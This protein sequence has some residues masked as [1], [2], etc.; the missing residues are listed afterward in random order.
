MN[1]H[2]SRS[3]SGQPTLSIDN[4]FIHSRYRPV[5]EARQFAQRL[6]VGSDVRLVIVL[7]DGL[8]YVSEAIAR[9]NRHVRVFGCC[10]APPT[11]APSQQ[12]VQLVSGDCSHLTA[13]LI[14]FA[15]PLDALATRVVPWPPGARA[16]ADAFDTMKSATAD[17]ILSLR[18]ELRTLS[19][20]GRRWISNSLRRSL[21]CGATAIPRSATEDVFVFAAGPTSETVASGAT[22][23]KSL[24]A[25]GRRP[26]VLAVSSAARLLVAN[27]II[28]DLVVHSDAGFWSQLFLRKSGVPANTPVSVTTRSAFPRSSVPPV[29]VSTGWLGDELFPDRGQLPKTTEA[30]SVVISALAVAK[31]FFPM[32]RCWIIGADMASRGWLDH[33]RPHLHDEHLIR[34]AVRMRPI[35]THRFERVAMPG[36]P[37]GRWPDGSPAYQTG[38]LRSYEPFL[39]QIG[40]QKIGPDSMRIVSDS[41]IWKDSEPQALSSAT[42]GSTARKIGWSAGPSIQLERRSRPDAPVR[43]KHVRRVLERW[44]ELL[45]GF[46]MRDPTAEEIFLYLSSETEVLQVGAGD[47]PPGRAVANVKDRLAAIM[48]RYELE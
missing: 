37:A 35:A 15:R 7:G 40:R 22:E 16:A 4:R 29:L 45:D 36:S 20:F 33:G 48:D 34:E 41:P 32:A 42:F 5:D 9:E 28:P 38:A 10:L 39:R 24:S 1:H 18:G 44:C 19:S 8:G 3:R 2:I 46:P 43:R 23:L 21:S 31:Q 30:P 26:I 14:Q 47:L 27:G 12:S 17:A 6:N 25:T 13:S 11:E